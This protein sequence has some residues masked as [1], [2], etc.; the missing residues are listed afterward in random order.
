MIALVQD[1]IRHKAHASASLL[2]AVSKCEAAAIDQQLLSLFHHIIVAN[3]FWLLSALGEPFSVEDESR[4]P[5]TIGAVIEQYRRTHD[6]ELAWVAGIN[7]PQL[8][9]T[10]KGPLV[11]GGERSI[12]EALL[13]VCLHSHGHRA[14][15]ATR[16]R[17]LGGTPPAMDFIVWVQDRPAPDWPET[18]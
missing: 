14:Q 13:Q 8:F 7:E 10:V 11:P 5:T 1:L 6:R 12:G 4:R 9:G 18:A 16:L 3:R 15:C 2:R 17:M